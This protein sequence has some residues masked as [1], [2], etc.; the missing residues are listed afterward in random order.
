MNKE[1]LV[2]FGTGPVAARSLL[3][4]LEDFEVEMVITKPK[5]SHHKSEPPVEAIANQAGLKLAF[6]STKQ[7]ITNTLNS[8]KPSSKAG[9]VIDFGIIIPQDS[10]DYF[11]EGIINSHFSL[12]PRWRGADPITYSILS[13]DEKTGVSLMKIVPELDAGPIIA[14]ESLTIDKI[15]SPELT[16]KLIQLSE[17]LLKKYVPKVINDEVSLTPQDSNQATYSKKIS[18]QDG[19]VDWT[20]PAEQIEREIRAYAGWPKSRTKLGEIDCIII[21]AEVLENSGIPGVVV[22][23]NQQL[24]IYC[25]K[26]SIKINR[27]MPS[28]K[29][30]M[31]S[32]EFIRGYKDRIS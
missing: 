22:T 29:K 16:S 17:K 10:I 2:F 28:G 19:I 12:L 24:L 9:L 13:G 27:L 23:D 25:S 26:G 7:D 8:L 30:A 5:A 20:K 11:A 6:V 21:S 32:S 18:K 15:D 14:Q 4:I 1:K 31:T 3:G